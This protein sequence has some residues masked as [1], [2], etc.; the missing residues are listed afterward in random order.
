ML[1]I[2]RVLQYTIVIVYGKLFYLQSPPPEF[3]IS[4][5]R[6]LDGIL[7]MDALPEYDECF[8]IAKE[9]DETFL[10]LIFDVLSGTRISIEVEGSTPIQYACQM[11]SEHA[12]RNEKVACGALK[13]FSSET[14]VML[15]SRNNIALGASQALVKAL[16]Q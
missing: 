12:A 6:T 13:L 15:L 16:S 10:Q 14:G 4:I 5:I 11:I 7:S 2:S 9:Y 1:D 8:N 3:I